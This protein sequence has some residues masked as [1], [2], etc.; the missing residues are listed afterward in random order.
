MAPTDKRTKSIETVPRVSSGRFCRGVSR[1][2]SSTL[3]VAEETPAPRVNVDAE[4]VTWIVVEAYRFTRA[5]PSPPGAPQ[6]ASFA[7]LWFETGS[8]RTAS[9]HLPAGCLG[10]LSDEDLLEFLAV[11]TA[12][13]G[14][15]P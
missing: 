12:R 9:A 11:A 2:T 7:L 5:V 15:Q 4:G 6:M 10:R 8:G 3:E 13:R 1:R 14:R